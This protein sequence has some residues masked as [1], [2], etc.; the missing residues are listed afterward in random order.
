MSVL[1]REN[2]ADICEM[3]RRLVRLYTPA[4]S[5]QLGGYVDEVM[6]FIMSKDY[7]FQD[8]Y[9]TSSMS[10]K[11]KHAKIPESVLDH[12]RINL[13]DLHRN[14]IAWIRD[15]VK[16]H[17]IKLRTD[18]PI[19][20]KKRSEIRGVSETVKLTQRGKLVDPNDQQWKTW[21]SHECVF[22][23]ILIALGLRFESV[24]NAQ[25]KDRISEIEKSIHSDMANELGLPKRT[26]ADESLV[27]LLEELFSW[28]RLSITTVG[29][30]SDRST[31][32]S[33]YIFS[34]CDN[35]SIDFWHVIYVER[36]CQRADDRGS[37]MGT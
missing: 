18:Q 14:D 5:F 34:Y 33:K 27:Y 9:N 21:G 32:G 13:R 3:I 17:A 23:G 19:G 24:G 4:T 36:K 22:S 30:F 1:R 7:I 15:T 6:E 29:Q 10:E 35:P 16:F 37:A 12:A 26:V 25:E 28:K 2:K 20:A 31:V 11:S 8:K